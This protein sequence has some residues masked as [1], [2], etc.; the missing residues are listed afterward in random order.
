MRYL[1]HQQASTPPKFWQFYTDGA[2]KSFPEDFMK[3][4]K[5]EMDECSRVLEQEGVKVVRPE[6]VNFSDL[7]TTPDFQ[8]RG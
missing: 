6:A 3:A 7:Y 2:G 4:A 5:K 8:S 1:C